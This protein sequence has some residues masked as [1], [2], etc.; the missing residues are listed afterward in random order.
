MP[1]DVSRPST[2]AALDT[3]EVFDH[4][5]RSRRSVRS[6][7]ANRPV[8]KVLLQR[9]LSTAAQAP[10]NSNTQPWQVHVLAGNA[11]T[12][13]SATLRRA[14]ENN[15]AP[16]FSHFPS[17]LPVRMA[18]HQADFG[19]RYYATLGIERTDTAARDAQTVRN[20]DFFGAPVGFLLTTHRD[21]HAHSWI[22]CGL[23]LQSL[24]L[25]AQA[26]GLATCPQV[27]FARFDALIGQHLGLPV[28]ERVVCGMSLGYAV[29]DAEVNGMNMPRRAVGEVARFHGF[30]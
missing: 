21:L 2:A 27:S 4:L 16:P 3:A 12:A 20:Y 19:A 14:C 30:A 17:P 6:F 23:F 9:V 13:L 1:Q 10:S 28:D 29:A 22:D 11:L 26:Q 5:M 18:E 8:S 7:V 15:D 25:A 24:M